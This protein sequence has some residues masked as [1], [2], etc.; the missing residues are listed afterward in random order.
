MSQQS[1]T[2]LGRQSGR[3]TT[4]LNKVNP[5]LQAQR[6]KSNLESLSSRPWG[7][8]QAWKIEHLGIK[9]KEY[10]TAIKFT[11]EKCHRTSFALIHKSYQ[12]FCPSCD[13]CF[14]SYEDY[15]NHLIIQSF[16]RP[17]KQTIEEHSRDKS[18]WAEKNRLGSS[19]RDLDTHKQY[20]LCGE[21]RAYD[22]EAML[23]E[24]K[25]QRAKA[26]KLRRKT[27]LQPIRMSKR[28][29]M[30]RMTSQ[31]QSTSEFENTMPNRHSM[32][33]RRITECRS[34]VAERPEMRNSRPARNTRMSVLQRD[35]NE[36]ESPRNSIPAARN[37]RLSVLATMKAHR[38]IL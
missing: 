33:P 10:Q 15:Q 4:V 38:P 19:R 30:R 7:R 3:R 27:R 21:M 34:S 9:P 29:F 11:K 25:K 12:T 22:E 5:Y 31:F 28:A 37:T 1:V 35:P 2:Q 23:E 16:M 17:Y 20:E 18:D 6:R 24:L 32:G 8:C 36:T 13:L 26:I 14:M